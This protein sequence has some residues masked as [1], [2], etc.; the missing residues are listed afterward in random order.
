MNEEVEAFFIFLSLLCPRREISHDVINISGVEIKFIIILLCYVI[1]GGAS[2]NRI[3]NSVETRMRNFT[4]FAS[5]FMNKKKTRQIYGKKKKS[6]NLQICEKI[7]KISP[8]LSLDF[9]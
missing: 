4:S 7:F 6:S 5:H 1:F 3:K 9:I 2:A 8:S